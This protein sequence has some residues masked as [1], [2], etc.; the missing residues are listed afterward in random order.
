MAE[1]KVVLSPALPDSVLLCMLSFVDGRTL[2]AVQQSSRRLRRLAA[3]TA[4]SDA[5]WCRSVVAFAQGRLIGQ[6]ESVP[7]VYSWRQRWARDR[8]FA[9]ALRPVAVPL[10][11]K[12]GATTVQ[13]FSLLPGSCTGA[14]GRF[15]PE[16]AAR[17]CEQLDPI[18]RVICLGCPNMGSRIKRVYGH[19]PEAQVLEDI[20][21]YAMWLTVPIRELVRRP[22]RSGHPRFIF[23]AGATFSED[24]NEIGEYETHDVLAVYVVTWERVV[25]FVVDDGNFGSYT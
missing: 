19:D 17:A 10:M 15:D 11:E 16:L 20:A 18:G 13:W 2:W 5:L 23:R 3:D 8:C 22:G 4:A 25:R 7:R 24:G 12:D 1:G 9:A 21:P 14:G 6:P